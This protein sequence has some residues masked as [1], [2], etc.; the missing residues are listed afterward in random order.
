MAANAPFLKFITFLLTLPKHY[1]FEF[2]MFKIL[3]S[4]LPFEGKE[5][6]FP[7]QR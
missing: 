1:Y 6:V 2:Y 4:N 7:T 3:G 5:R